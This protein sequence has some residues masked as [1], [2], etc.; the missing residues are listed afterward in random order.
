MIGSYR[1]SRSFWFQLMSQIYKKQNPLPAQDRIDQELVIKNSGLDW[2]I[3]KPPR[4]TNGAT[5]LVQA[6]QNIKV[7][8]TS[9]ISRANLAKFIIAELLKPKF[10]GQA[11]FV[12]KY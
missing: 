4:L 2:T 7:G 6:G 9:S 11:I 3:I 1:Q 8:M 10:I 12:R 5:L